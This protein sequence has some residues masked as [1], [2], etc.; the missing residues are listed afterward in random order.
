MS[1]G[2]RIVDAPGVGR[3]GAQPPLRVHG[4][5]HAD[6]LERLVHE[7][8]ELFHRR[9][10]AELAGGALPIIASLGM[11]FMTEPLPETDCVAL[12]GP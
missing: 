3:R 8:V 5:L 7:G 2:A 12:G 1:M 9:L 6:L 10:G 4:L 11:E